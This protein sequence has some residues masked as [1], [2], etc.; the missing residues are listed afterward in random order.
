[1]QCACVSVFLP[2]QEND[3]LFATQRL[4][5]H[6]TPVQY[7]GVSFKTNSLENY[8][9]KCDIHSADTVNFINIKSVQK[10]YQ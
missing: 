3:L 9:D 1:M 2:T 10:L 5:P 7:T 6:Q 4:K 8:H